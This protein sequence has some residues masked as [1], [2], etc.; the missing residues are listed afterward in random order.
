MTDAK[1]VDFHYDYII[2]IPSYNRPKAIRKKTLDMLRRNNISKGQIILFLKDEQQEAMYNLSDEY[3]VVLT[4][5][6]GIKATRNFLQTY[7]FHSKYDVV[8]YLD[9][10]INDIIDI[11]GN[12]MPWG[13]YG[14]YDLTELIT[15]MIIELQTRGLSVCGICPY[16]NTFF[17][18]DNISTNL[19]LIIGLFRLEIIN[20]EHL[21]LCTCGQFEDYEFSIEYFLRDGGVLRYNNIGVKT[22]YCWSK[23]GITDQL[24]GIENRKKEMKKNADYL[25]LKYGGDIVKPYKKKD[26]WDLKLNYNY[27]P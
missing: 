3:K 22:K 20:K 10:D 7:F 16:D 21:I 13:G 14:E 4:R 9:D 25:A 18:K 17:L 5:A 24:G 6:E 12:T 15:M 23:G 8:L 19:K 11:A 2:A 1:Q 26:G 27:K